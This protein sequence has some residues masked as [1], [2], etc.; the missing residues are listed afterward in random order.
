MTGVTRY[1]WAVNAVGWFVILLSAATVLTSPVNPIALVL[2][3]LAALSGFSVLRLRSISAS[4]SLGDAFTL[5]ALFLQ[6]PEFGALAVA[7]E[8]T[9]ISFRL[10]GPPHR[11]LFNSAA[12]A[13][14]MWCAGWV[15]FRVAGLPLPSAAPD[16]VTMAMAAVASVVLYF[17]FGS[18][19]V[20]TAVALDQRGSVQQVWREHFAGLWISPAT[21]GYIAVLVAL[22]SS[23]IGAG[24]VLTVLPMPVIVYQMLRT[25][26][27]RTD[28]QLRH[29]EA[30]NRTYASTIEAFATAVDAKDQVTHG[31]LRRVQVYALGV[32]KELGITDAPTLRSLEA[33]ALLHDVGKIGIP[34][35]ILNKP[36]KLTPGEFEEMK[37]HVIIGADILATVDFPFPVVPIV[38][39]HHENWDGTGYPDGVRGTDI[40]LG[41]RILMVVDCFDALTSDRPYRPAMSRADAFEILRE[42][43][44]RMYDPDIVDRFIAVQPCLS[45]TLCLESNVATAEMHA[46]V[47]RSESRVRITAATEGLAAG[48]PLARL[49]GDVLTDCLAVIYEVDPTGSSIVAKAA[50]G[51]AARS[52]IG[53]RLLVGHGVSGWVSANNQAIDDTDAALDLAGVLPATDIASLSCTSVP[54]S[55]GGGR[56][57]VTVYGPRSSA[58][59]RVTLVRGLS[60]YFQTAA[61]T[62]LQPAPVARTPVDMAK[63]S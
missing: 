39:H 30:M 6:G 2:A 57:V 41:A 62:G 14:A 18:S 43:R 61:Q 47:R 45:E 48:E 37:R 33:A 3:G 23:E 53:H 46:A 12:P 34:E 24:A 44:G 16:F 28:D 58:A 52:V 50:R 8:T 22:L 42:R 25:S 63:A 51:Q 21:G 10:G 36:G 1:V 54:M 29:L 60:R 49:L 40:P 15:T 31:H 7:L 55:V 20:A 5:S 9:A 32:A 35:H 19:L 38:R 56:M 59:Q 11:L 4:Y 27:A 13:L 26:L 17:L